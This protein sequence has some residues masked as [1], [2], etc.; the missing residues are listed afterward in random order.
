MSNRED[1]N[2]YERSFCLKLAK[3]GFWVHNMAQNASGQPADVIAVKDGKA[4]L[5]DCKVCS[6]GKFAF[7]RVEENQHYSMKYWNECGNGEGWFAIKLDLITYM[8]PYSVIEKYKETQS[9]LTT[10]NIFEE[11]YPL[12]VWVTEQ[13]Q[14][15]NKCSKCSND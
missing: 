13:L 15:E 3:Y 11:G 2:R 14:H 9:Y 7:S 4:Y 1:G 5:I 6:K 10:E 8:I 12:K